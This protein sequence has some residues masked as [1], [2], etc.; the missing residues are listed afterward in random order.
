MSEPEPPAPEPPDAVSPVARV[1]RRRRRALVLGGAAV[2]V[3]IGVLV[4]VLATR[5][6]HRP[7]TVTAGR[8]GGGSAALRAPEGPHVP[9]VITGV[10]L[11]GFVVDGA[12]LPVAGA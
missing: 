2:I 7:A 5:R 9:V 6:T 10:H 3:A 11:T 8:D 1:P 4:L 12:G